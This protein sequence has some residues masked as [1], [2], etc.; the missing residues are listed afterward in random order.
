[1]EMNTQSRGGAGTGERSVGELLQELAGESSQLA[2]QEIALARAELKRSLSGVGRDA[3]AIAMSAGMAVIG[4]ITVLAF[5]IAALGD[6]LDNYW[7]AALIVGVLLAGV[8]AFLAMRAVRDLRT[9]G[10]APKE[11]IETLRTTGEW[12]AEEATHLRA[13][14]A[15]SAPTPTQ[16]VR[17]NGHAAVYDTLAHRP[18]TGRNGRSTHAAERARETAPP[19]EPETR[20][21]GK[22]AGKPQGL[23]KAV[24]QEIKDDDITGQ[25][26]KIAYYAF[27]ALPPAIMAL[28]GLAGLFGTPQLAQWVEDQALLAAPREVAE[29][30][31]IPFIEQ[32]V[33]NKAPGAFSIGLLLALWGASAVFTGLMDTLNVAYDVKETRSFVK[34]RAIALGMML[35]GALLFLL[36]AVSLLSG[37]KILETIG[38]G[39]T[40]QLI[41]GLVK[42]PL[43]FAFIAIAFWLGYYL[44]PNKDQK[45]CKKVL[46]KAAAGA[47]LLWVVATA[48][49]R[50]Y[51]ANFSSYSETYGF[52][53]A[54][55]I[56]L[57][58]L[59]VTGL[60]VLAGG[61]LASEMERRS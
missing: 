38:L 46:L 1:M 35:A 10:F 23:V 17:G 54:F 39:A 30:I 44:L 14:L 16:A 59:Y 56:L 31:L 21:G 42:W 3:G 7:L 6:L 4:G 37:P 53:G 8:G 25:A 28:F 45:G 49:F 33:L 12:A 29:S 61:E 24:L 57:L 52:L 13:T 41:W 55:I 19:R 36:A 27:M 60:V 43:A 5:L 47:A 15:G 32:V 11:T 20:R 26:A 2:R 51:I 18:S 9:V 50:I 22:A 48:A 58:W 40:G 34:K